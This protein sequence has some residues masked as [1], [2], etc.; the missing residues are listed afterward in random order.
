[1]PKGAQGK[2]K[3]IRSPGKGPSLIADDVQFT[4][5]TIEAIPVP[6]AG[7]RNPQHQVDYKEH[8]LNCVNYKL[9]NF[10]VF[11]FEIQNGF[12]MFRGIFTNITKIISNR[13][14][15]RVYLSYVRF[16]F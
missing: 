10:E 2:G 13:Q 12:N 3:V 9:E 14:L 1:M 7:A 15:K 8:V 16:S 5:A 6:E 4:Y 11:I